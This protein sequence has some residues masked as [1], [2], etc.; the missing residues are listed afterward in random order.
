MIDFN[1]PDYKRS[2]GAYLA[3]CAAEHF[4]VLLTTGAYLAKLLTYIGISDSLAGIISSFITLAFTIQLF[5]VFIVRLKCSTK[6]LV[7]FFEMVCSLFFSAIFLVPFMPVGK[8]LKTLFV[9]IFILIAYFSRYIVQ[10]LLF[11]WG[12]S[13]VAP[14]KRASFSAVKE[15]IS[16]FLGMLVTA[17]AGFI[18]D[19]LEGLGNLNGAFLFLAVSIFALTVVNLVTLLLIRKEDASEHT[20]DSVP[21]STVLKNTFGN[22]NFRSVVFLMILFDTA[23]YFTTGFMNTYKIKDLALSILAVEIINIVANF[24]RMIVSVPFGR[25]S[26]RH[27]FAKGFKLGLFFFAAAFFI[28]IFTTKEAWFL[29]IAYTVFINIAT[30]GT[31]QNSFNIMYS[32][33]DAPYV[34]QAMSIC[35]CISGLFGFGASLLG[36]KI[37]SLVQANGNT[38]FGIPVNGQQILSGISLVLTAASI[39]YITKVIEKQPILHQ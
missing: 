10:T 15:A 33:V 11:K 32:Y 7:I 14:D 21:F 34:T 3:Q 6:F 29:V 23:R 38:V 13:F 25:Y 28:N 24:A 4:I 16:L 27:S 26:D 8:T 2:R 39:L 30:A 22:K 9:I 31:N 12:S 19:R 36:G 20:A 18:V 37:L 35:R 5:S 1:S 17:F